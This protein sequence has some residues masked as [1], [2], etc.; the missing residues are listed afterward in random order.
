MTISISKN[1]VIAALVTLIATMNYHARVEAQESLAA[2]TAPNTEVLPISALSNGADYEIY[3]KLPKGYYESDESYPLMIALDADYS[4]SIVANIVEHLA[5]RG[6]A[7]NMIVVAIAYPGV[8]PDMR[9]YRRTRTRDYTPFH[10]PSGGY[11]AKIQELSGGGPAFQSFIADELI[12]KL[13]ARYRL[14]GDRTLVGHS[15]GGLFGAWMLLSRPETFNRYILVSPSLW[16]A[17]H[18][19]LNDEVID[20]GEEIRQRT[21]VYMGVG[22]WENQPEN[23]RAMVDELITFS[24]KLSA[25]KDADL[26]VKHRVFEDETHASIFPVALSTG[27]RHLFSTMED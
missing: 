6:Q 14:N 25:R 1:R 22:D 5:D 11:G 8:Y 26:L 19:F 2:Y 20:Q 18:H 21:L 3:V 15:Y 24:E 16:Y 23:G 13:K 17:D 12:P 27:I 7:P 10:F 4:F 9:E